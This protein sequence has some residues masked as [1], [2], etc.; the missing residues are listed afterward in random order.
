[1]RYDLPPHRRTEVHYA[2]RAQV[3]PQSTTTHSRRAVSSAVCSVCARVRP[4]FMTTLLRR[5]HGR[6]SLCT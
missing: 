1:M 4:G 6:R 5:P 3:H 2:L